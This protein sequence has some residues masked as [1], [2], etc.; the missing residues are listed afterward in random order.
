MYE[1]ARLRNDQRDGVGR[2]SSAFERRPGD[3]ELTFVRIGRL[4]CEEH[5]HVGRLQITRWLEEC[6]KAEL[7]EKREAQVRANEAARHEA[8]KL[9][10]RDMGKLLREAFR[11]PIRDNRRVSITVARHAAQHLRIRRNGGWIVS[12]CPNGDWRV[13]TRR[14]SA[15]EL[16]E[17]AKKVGFRE[18]DDEEFHCDRERRFTKQA[19]RRVGG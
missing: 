13:G 5:Y 12:P 11:E 4:A 18:S 3:F 15:A 14:V 16:V 6:G 1:M 8:A 2:F 19:V 10:R 9:S 17:M 7:K